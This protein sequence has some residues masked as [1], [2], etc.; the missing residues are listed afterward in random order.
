[1]PSTPEAIECIPIGGCAV[2]ARKGVERGRRCDF[3]SGNESEFDAL[4]LDVC[5]SGREAE[6]H[7]GWTFTTTLRQRLRRNT[8]K[9]RQSGCRREHCGL[10]QSSRRHARPRRMTAVPSD[11]CCRVWSHRNPGREAT[12]FLS[13][14]GFILGS[15][16]TAHRVGK[17]LDALTFLLRVGDLGGVGGHSSF[18]LFGVCFVLCFYWHD[19]CLHIVCILQLFYRILGLF[20]PLV[21]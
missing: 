9:R 13:L 3:G 11:G 2:C 6:G 10:P 5:G 4:Q 14:F 8:A 7:Y 12:R 19:M 18:F 16:L 1:M 17:R 15:H 20:T 21:T